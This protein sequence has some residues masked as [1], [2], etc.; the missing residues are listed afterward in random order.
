MNELQF[1]QGT[2]MAFKLQLTSKRLRQQIQDRQMAPC[3][4]CLMANSIP[5]LEKADNP[6]TEVKR[7]VI[8][9]EVTT[10]ESELLCLLVFQFVQ[11]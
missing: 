6:L 3:R 5:M 11:T 4:Q 2:P 10:E 7:N 9:N 1:G 8:V